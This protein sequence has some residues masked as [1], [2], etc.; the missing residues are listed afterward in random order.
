MW[1]WLVEGFQTRRPSLRM[2]KKDTHER[3]PEIKGWNIQ[4][5]KAECIKAGIPYQSAATIVPASQIQG[6]AL[7]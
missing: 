5:L 6:A 1:A 3:C 7:D 4:D 2:Q